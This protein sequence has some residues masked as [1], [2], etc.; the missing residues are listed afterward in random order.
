M[1]NRIA[2]NISLLPFVMVMVAT[3]AAFAGDLNAPAAPTD[4]GSAMFT[5]DDIYNRLNAGTQG[6][7][8]I[9]PFVEPSAAPGST[10]RNLNDIMSKAPVVDNTAGAGAEHVLAGKTYW[11]LQSGNWGLQTG[12]L[13]N[14]GTM[15][16]T[17]SIAEQ[18]ITA[19]FHDGTG[20]VAGDA[21][22]VSG[23]IKAGVNL[24]GVDGNAAVVNTSSANA[25][26]GEVL[27]ERKVWVN[28]Q[29]VTGTMPNNGAV[30]LTPGTTDQTI[31][32]G[33]HDGT[34]KVAG[35]A[36][37]VPANIA[38]ATTVFGVTGMR[39]GGVVLKAGG[40]FFEGKPRWYV[41]NDGTITDVKTGLV[42]LSEIDHVLH[43]FVA[44]TGAPI[45]SVRYPLSVRNGNPP[46]LTDNSQPGDWDM[47]TLVEMQSLR[48]SDDYNHQIGGGY[49]GPFYN[50]WTNAYYWTSTPPSVAYGIAEPDK[51][52]VINMATGEVIAE[53]KLALSAVGH[54]VW[55]V[56]RKH[57]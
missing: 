34:G 29:E 54:Y 10:M 28:G 12:T 26:A 22:L 16:I 47:P 20:K 4:A 9:G 45:D 36:N 55:L 40:Y 23:N 38:A 44:S 3:F 39:A 24:F 50:L 7:K 21:D 8:R 43:P 57:R 6:A 35:D 1:K 32:A 15:N 31:A 14:V 11:G 27:L 48:E 13:A 18:T 37:L 49:A 17:P 46:L 33:Y 52:A 56:R 2:R 41:N 19:G 53:D 51:V 30:N 25:T 42:W 5:L